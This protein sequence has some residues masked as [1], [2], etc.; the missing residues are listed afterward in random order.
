MAIC[1]TPIPLSIVTSLLEVL[2][3]PRQGSSM[4]FYGSLN[5]D[6]LLACI[7]RSCVL[8]CWSLPSSSWG[9]ANRCA[10]GWCWFYIVKNPSF[11]VTNRSLIIHPSRWPNWPQ[12]RNLLQQW[13]LLFHWHVVWGNYDNTL[14][15]QRELISPQ[16]VV[17]WTIFKFKTT[18]W[19]WSYLYAVVQ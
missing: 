16:F 3:M 8:S 4:Q 17:A 9:L 13:Q 15:L 18:F 2:V 11:C 7:L 1:L 19:L 12:H 6:S 14:T 5:F 10:D